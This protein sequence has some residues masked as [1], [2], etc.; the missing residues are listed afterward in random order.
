[1]LCPSLQSKYGGSLHTA[2]Q[3]PLPEYSPIVYLSPAVQSLLADWFAPF[4]NGHEIES[5]VGTH[6]LQ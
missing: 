6:P 1:M 4:P 3:G 5:D 2:T